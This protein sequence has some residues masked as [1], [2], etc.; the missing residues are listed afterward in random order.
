MVDDI[1]PRS[2]GLSRRLTSD[3]LGLF[4][5]PRLR[6]LKPRSAYRESSAA[7]VDIS[8]LVNQSAGRPQLQPPHHPGL[9][10]NRQV[11]RLQARSPG[12]SGRIHH[13]NR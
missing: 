1:S 6:S 4:D 12:D 2:V 8:S 3:P 5:E 9:A 7:R 11:E 13:T 10:A